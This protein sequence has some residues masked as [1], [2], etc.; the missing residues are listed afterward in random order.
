MNNYPKWWDTTVT[1]YNKFTDTQTQ[2][3]TWYKTI[4]NGCFWKDTGNKVTINNVVLETNNIICRIRKDPKFLERSEWVALP[5]DEMGNYFTL[6]PGDIIIRGS[7]DEDID[8]Y[9]SGKRATD[10][11]KKYKALQGC[12]EIQAV[13]NNTGGGRGNEHYHV[14]GI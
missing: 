9:K 2:V 1:V 3:V 11:T 14:T 12:M 13:T 8:E 10:L 7:V 5:N 6:S 4:I